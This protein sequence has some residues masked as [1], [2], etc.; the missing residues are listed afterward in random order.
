M[1][2]VDQLSKSYG[3][4]DAIKNVSF[5]V[6]PGE[7]LGFLGP[8]G[9]GKTTTMRIL[10][11]YLPAT[12]GTARVAGKDVHSESMAVRQ[13]IGYLPETPPLYPEMTVEGFLHFVAR[14]KGVSARSEERR[15]GKECLL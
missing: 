3:S 2:E 10:T 5:T 7:I 4:T 8:N 15:V 13:N 11:G 12:T 9:A 1:I 6:E 14:I